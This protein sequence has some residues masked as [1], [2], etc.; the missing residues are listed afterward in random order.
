MFRS[1]ETLEKHRSLCLALI[2]FEK[3]LNGMRD[4]VQL[5]AYASE[6]A[7]DILEVFIG[8]QNLPRVT[9]L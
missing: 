3:F 1:L 5:I 9:N 2:S 7:I 4:S 8:S 6:L